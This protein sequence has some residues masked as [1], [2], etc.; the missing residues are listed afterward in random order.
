MTFRAHYAIIVVIRYVAGKVRVTINAGKLCDM[1]RW[2]SWDTRN[3]ETLGTKKRWDS[4]DS[5]TGHVWDA[6]DFG[7]RFG[8]LL[9]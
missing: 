4:W 3:D 5:G 8:K 2:D 6:R 1:E 7:P 9:R